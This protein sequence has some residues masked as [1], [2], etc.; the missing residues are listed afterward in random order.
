MASTEAPIAVGDRGLVPD[1]GLSRGMTLLFAAAA[2]LAV[3][4]IYYAQPLLIAISSAFRVS[5]GTA[6]LI[7]TAGQLGYTVG[8]ALLVPVGDITSRR[9]LATALLGVTALA[10]AVCATAPDFAVLAA[11]IAVMSTGAVAGP[12]LLPFA[13]A[14]A[15]PAQRGRV[16][17]TVMSGVLFGVLLSRVAGG[18]IAQALGWRA[19]YGI[20]AGVTFVL[21]LVLWRVLPEVPPAASARYLPLLR[22]IFTLLR[23]QPVL[24]VRALL[25]FFG[26]GTFTILWTSVAFLLARP[27]YSFDEGVIGLFGLAGAAGALAARVAGPAAD[28]G[29]DRL[30]TGSMLMAI[31]A[32]WVLIGAD[33]GH[34]LAAVAVGIVV[35]DLGVQGAH[36]TNLAVIY[37]RCAAARARL[38]TVYFTAVFLGGVA[39]A[40]T[41]GIA[42]ASGGWTAVSLA[43][44]G[45]T[46]AGLV[47]WAVAARRGIDRQ[48]SE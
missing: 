6:S 32:G 48:D 37:R 38:T 40:A 8:I 12:V 29:R 39:G 3:A 2:G 22:S 34:V 24:R 33:G 11:A 30:V 13:A 18:L 27:P 26:F 42:Y 14:L 17:G 46:L 10:L 1:G 45:F 25:G 21:A 44:G 15:A 7:S 16:T 41:S 31:L 28:R 35:L 47:V 4:N 36:V 43:G 5:S 9:R 20:A 19:V 23:T